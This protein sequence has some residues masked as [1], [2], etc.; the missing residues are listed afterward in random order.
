M[1]LTIHTLINCIQNFSLLQTITTMRKKS[2][3]SATVSAKQFIPILREVE[4]G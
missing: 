1:G 4:R 3:Y 2:I